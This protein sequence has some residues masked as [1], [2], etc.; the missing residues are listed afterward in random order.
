MVVHFGEVQVHGLI[1][2]ALLERLS[3]LSVPDGITLNLSV[4]RY[5]FHQLQ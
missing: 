5:L 1:V 3:C 2:E 4:L